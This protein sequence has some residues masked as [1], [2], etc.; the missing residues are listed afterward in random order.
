MKNFDTVNNGSSV[1]SVRDSRMPGD[2]FNDACEQMIESL[3]KGGLT[4]DA[5][6]FVEGG[7][8]NACQ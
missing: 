1:V 8:I 7:Q 2:A 4:A 3:E 6:Q 5:N